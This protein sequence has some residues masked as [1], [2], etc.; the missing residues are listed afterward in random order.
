MKDVY[1]DFVNHWANDG[2]YRAEATGTDLEHRRCGRAGMIC[3][4]RAACGVDLVYLV[5]VDHVESV[6]LEDV[7]EGC[8]G[9]T[10]VVRYC[11]G[12]GC[13][14][15]LLDDATLLLQVDL[16]V[17]CEV[18][19]LD[20]HFLRHVLDHEG[21][22]LAAYL[23]QDVKDQPRH[24]L[25]DDELAHQL[26]LVV[27]LDLRLELRFGSLGKLVLDLAALCS[28]IDVVLWLRLSSNG[29]GIELTN[30]QQGQDI[31]L[32]LLQE[33]QLLNVAQKVRIDQLVRVVDHH[34]VYLRLTV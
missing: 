27:L 11:Y 1:S 21:V 29:V 2:A 20:E 18:E 7:E 12:P 26:L 3:A 4:G 14:L 22:L 15:E 17:H 13:F 28:R 16:T 32:I 25:Q 23:G 5:W 34:V 8:E 6:G 19:H 10:L 24:V 30:L 9:L 33:L 31:L